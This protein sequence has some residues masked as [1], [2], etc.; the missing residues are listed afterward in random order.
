[1]SLVSVTYG[2][3]VTTVVLFG[4][5]AL[6]L[7]RRRQ[8]IKPDDTEFF[9]TARHS[10]PL[11]TIAW[12]FY[13]SGVGA[14]VIFSMP[15]YVVSA[16]MVGLVA[17]S[18][19]CGLPIIIVARV[20]AVLHRKYPGVLSLGDFVEWRFGL[21]PT[22]II[23]MVMLLNM[24]IALCAEYTSIGNLMEF[25][26][27]GPRLPIVICV[28]AVTSIYTA[29]GGL[30]VSILTDVAQGVF[31]ILLL[32]IMA[33]YVAVTYRPESL[34]TPLPEE[35]GPNYWGWAAV[36]AMPISMT[37]AT[38]FSEAPWQRIWASAD[39]ESL[40]KGSL[41]GALALIV[42]CFLYGFGGFL[43]IWAGYPMS[44]ADGSTAFFDLLSAGK[45]S[46]PNWIVILAAL[47]TVTMNEGCVDSLQNG[48]VDTVAS[49]FFRG[50]SVWYPRVLVFLINIPIVFVSLKG[51]N[52]IILFLIGN[53]ICTIC[54]IPLLLGLVTRL[55]GYVTGWSMVSG[56]VTGFFSIAVFG[57]IKM[58]NFSDG[59]HYT[60][61]ESYDWP[62]FVLPLVFSFIG[63]FVAA[64]IEGVIRKACGFAYPVPLS[65]PPQARAEQK[66][67]DC[68][69][70][71]GEAEYGR[72]DK[73]EVP[74]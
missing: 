17:Y 40:K 7:A 26:I 16:G 67:K 46:A 70:S 56:I 36:G 29:A 18:V 22:I 60:F 9:L 25:V 10:V 13:A 72:D 30:Y 42:V 63:V 43:A 23:T 28:A 62:S 15:A 21:I 45:S 50:K 33:I 24:F 59:L 34:P 2:L 31:G 32:V 6:Y 39:E 44:S 64:A 74:I 61:V 58:G 37:C 71:L 1:M 20:G 38:F 66:E 57:Y 53:L 41:I 73:Q 27:G 8:Q 51:Y 69:S 35:L 5:G 52:I 19:S 49:R 47:A 65:L 54:A 3:S 68:V 4:L 12:S 14:W 11:K 48:I 55:E